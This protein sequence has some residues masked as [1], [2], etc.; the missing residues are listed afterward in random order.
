MSND[1]EGE[2]SYVTDNE[3]YLIESTSK[4]NIN[5]NG[6][7][8]NGALGNHTLLNE[9]FC[10][11]SLPLKAP[12]ILSSLRTTLI[13]DSESQLSEVGTMSEVGSQISQRSKSS[14]TESAVGGARSSSA[15]SGFQRGKST[16]V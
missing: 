1:T 14:Q 5:E 13:N 2:N 7:D 15:G 16:K 10:H 4:L 3:F 6:K 8:S 12:Q 11:R 9:T